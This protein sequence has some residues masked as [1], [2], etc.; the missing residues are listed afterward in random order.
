MN[1]REGEGVSGKMRN[2]MVHKKE[3]EE[4]EKGRGDENHRDIPL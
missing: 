2:Y 1:W 3:M 4:E